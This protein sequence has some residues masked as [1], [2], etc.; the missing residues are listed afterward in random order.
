MKLTRRGL[1]KR[2]GVV[3]ACA[4]AGQRVEVVGA[5]TSP[6]DLLFKNGPI[7]TLEDRPDVAEALA[8]RGGTI[9]A[10]GSLAEVSRLAGARCSS[11]GCAASFDRSPHR[12]WLLRTR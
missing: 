10:V 8:V 2:S 11:R 12:G 1:L 9:Q 5:E 4:L 7:L 3:A 6:A